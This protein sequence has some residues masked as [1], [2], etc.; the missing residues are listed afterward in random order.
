MALTESQIN[1]YYSALEGAM[2]GNTVRHLLLRQLRNSGSTERS[3]LDYAVYIT[4][5]NIFFDAAAAAGVSCPDDVSVSFTNKDIL[6]TAKPCVNHKLDVINEEINSLTIQTNNKIEQINM[7]LSQANNLIN[8]QNEQLAAAYIKISSLE[9]KV[10][11][12]ED[13][14]EQLW[15]LVCQSK[16]IDCSHIL[17]QPEL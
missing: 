4:G 12:L 14:N 8:N 17:D 1:F 11:S 5:R 13:K 6:R 3:F 9:D 10:E 16:L 7:A 15:N 2:I